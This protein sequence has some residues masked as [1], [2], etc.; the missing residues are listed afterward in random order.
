MQSLRV[1]QVPWTNPVAVGLRDALRAETYRE[2][3]RSAPPV[4]DD[5]TDVAVFL[6]TYELA[7]G[8]PVGCGGL[9]HV[10]PVR[11]AVDSLYVLP[12]ARWSGVSDAIIQELISWARAHGVTA[13]GPGIGPVPAGGLRVLSVGSEPSPTG[14]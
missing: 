14:G 10:D 13:I 1:R 11:V 8:Q 2:R 12:Y 6:I 9:R 7:T 4:P 3:P 5:G